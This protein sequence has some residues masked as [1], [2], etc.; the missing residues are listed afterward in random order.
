M[1]MEIIIFNFFGSFMLLTGSS[2][3]H[4]QEFPP[5]AS[6]F[7][8]I[9]MSTEMT[10]QAYFPFNSAQQ[11]VSCSGL[12]MGVNP[13]DVGLRRNISAPVSMPEMF[14]DPSCFAVSFFFANQS[15]N[16]FIITRF[17]Y[18][19]CVHVHCSTCYPLQLGR[20]IYK[21]FTMWALIIKH[22]Q[23]PFLLNHSQVAKSL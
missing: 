4:L 20:L 23:H 5:P 10:N 19:N 2:I 13:S 6:S 14:L 15:P 8:T 1:K 3:C 22:D 16:L 18:L 21:T 12:D 7:P 9:G 17:C 11:I